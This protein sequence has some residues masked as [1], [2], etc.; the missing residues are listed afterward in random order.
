MEWRQAEQIAAMHLGDQ[1]LVHE[2]M[3]LAVLQTGEHLADLSPISVEEAREILA[4]FYRNAVRRRQRANSKFSFRGTASELDLLAS[5]R[6]AA[7]PALEAELDLEAILRETPPDL[8]RAMLMR[9]GAHTPWED[10][11]RETSNSKEAIRKRC[12][13]ELVRIRRKLGIGDG[14][15]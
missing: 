10:I 1:T 8:R 5:S 14:V 2:L 4:R 15:D 13:R 11:A 12:Q 9:Y 7:V 6:D 3:E